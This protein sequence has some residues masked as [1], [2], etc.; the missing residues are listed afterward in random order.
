MFRYLKPALLLLILCSFAI[1]PASA[2]EDMAQRN[3]QI[4][5]DAVAEYNAGNR[6][7]YYTMV[8]DP[9]MMNQGES[10]LAETTID[11]LRGY[12]GALASAMPDMQMNMDVVLAQGDWVAAQVTYTGTFTE[13]FS[14]APFGPDA[15]DPN[16]EAITWTENDFLH[17]N[18]D[19]LIDKVWG[20]S[21]PSVLFGQLGV[22]PP[23]DDGSGSDMS[24][25][26][27]DY[28]PLS[29]DALAA[30][31]TSGMEDRNTGVIQTILDQ[32]MMASTASFYT[33]PYFSHAAGTVTAVDPT[34]DEFD[35]MF[36][37]VNTAIPDVKSEVTVQVAQGDWVAYLITL[38]GEFTG[39]VDMG[40]DMTLTPTGE[41]ITWQVAFINR[42]NADGLITDEWFEIDPMSLM[43][44]LGLMPPMDAS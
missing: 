17:F 5:M 19:G 37:A 36:M 2:Q 18:A 4:Y 24:S 22:F 29:G 6:E 1:M 28:Q 38:S 41:T 44:G 34:Q 10:A 15:F 16:N 8:T 33:N 27:T 31:F 23:M 9:F 32:D 35:P 13:P 12:D 20:I 42:F 39:E 21:D 14:F 43:M 3:K 7:A 26:A 25:P 40:P 11:D 30:S